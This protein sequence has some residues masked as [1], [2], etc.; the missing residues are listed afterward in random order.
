MQFYVKELFQVR[1]LSGNVDNGNDIGAFFATAAITAVIAAYV[2]DTGKVA[3]L[4]VFILVTLNG[5]SAVVVDLVI[6]DLAVVTNVADTD[7]RR[8]GV[9]HANRCGIYVSVSRVVHVDACRNDLVKGH[10]GDLKFTGNDLFLD[11][12]QSNGSGGI[13]QYHYL[14][15]HREITGSIHTDQ[16]CALG[17]L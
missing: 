2:A 13:L 8:G 14:F 5:L 12:G 15:F 9:E 16:V 3:E 17:Q 7:G 6:K 11:G 1:G 4:T 10:T